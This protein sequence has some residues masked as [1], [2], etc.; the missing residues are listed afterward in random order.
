[1]GT[2]NGTAGLFSFSCISVVELLE[3]RDRGG[4]AQRPG[5]RQGTL[6]G[7]RGAQ[8]GTRM[9]GRRRAWF[10]SQGQVPSCKRSR[11]TFR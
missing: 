5:L 1:M 9:C 2:A 7:R 3:E 8:A 11:W 4:R 10:S 6:A